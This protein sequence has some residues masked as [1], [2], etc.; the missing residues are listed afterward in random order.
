MAW[1]EHQGKSR[2]VAQA[3]IE[4]LQKSL[5]TGQVV[6]LTVM[7]QRT[8]FA[9]DSNWKGQVK[10]VLEDLQEYVWRLEQG[11]DSA[12]T[13]RPRAFRNRQTIVSNC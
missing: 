10:S 12:A 13:I 1:T 6:E 3:Q 4:S 11:H 8:R 5:L 2:E 7:G 9:E